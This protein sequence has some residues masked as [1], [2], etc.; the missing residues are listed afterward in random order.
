MN[1]K[2]WG[3]QKLKKKGLDQ[4]KPRR[5]TT[6]R[7]KRRRRFVLS[8]ISV[9]SPLVGEDE[10]EASSSTCNKGVRISGGIWRFPKIFFCHPTRY[11]RHRWLRHSER[12]APN[13]WRRIYKA[14][15]GEVGTRHSS[16][17]LLYR[18]N[19][20]TPARPGRRAEMSR[21]TQDDDDDEGNC[22]WNKINVPLPLRSSAIHRLA[23]ICI[24]YVMFTPTN[25]N[26]RPGPP[27]LSGSSSSGSSSVK[28]MWR[29]CESCETCGKFGSEFEFHKKNH[30]LTK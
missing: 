27:P 1:K 17:L 9:L 8:L 21:R 2:D 30:H 6:A 3:N 5:T 25:G 4:K 13:S 26:K 7:I 28:P 12:L 23:A 19:L 24:G 22:N 14:R 16:C 10:A 15:E 29:C 20:K 18:L 11:S